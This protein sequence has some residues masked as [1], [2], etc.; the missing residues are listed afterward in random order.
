MPDNLIDDDGALL[1]GVTDL[2][3]PKAVDGDVDGH[4]KDDDLK[5]KPDGDKDADPPKD[6]DEPKGTPTEF[7]DF[8]LPEGVERS[9]EDTAKFKEFAKENG[10][11]QKQAQAISDSQVTAAKQAADS[12][13]KLWEDENKKWQQAAKTDKEFGG[14]KFEESLGVAKKAMQKFGTTELLQVVDDYGMGNH[15][16]FIRLLFRVGNAM[17]EDSIITG[18][19]ASA[20]KSAADMLFPNQNS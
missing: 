16:E 19:G 18:V 13:M 17:S 14:L 7:E 10:L 3:K 4:A 6:A 5:D 20:P 2:D 8:T 9:E 11:T 12:S 1:S 15:P